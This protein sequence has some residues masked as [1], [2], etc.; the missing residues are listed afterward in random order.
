MNRHSM[1]A[2]LVLSIAAAACGSS[3]PAAVPASTDTAPPEA[4]DAPATTAAS[5]DAATDDAEVS[6]AEIAGRWYPVAVDGVALDTTEGDYWDF[7][8]TDARLEITGFDG[9]NNFG[10][11][12]EPDTASASIVDGRLDNVEIATEEAACEGVDSGPYPEDGADL[13][14]SDDATNLT[15]KGS[16]TTVDLSRTEPVE[17]DAKVEVPEVPEVSSDNGSPTTERPVESDAATGSVDGPLMRHPEPSGTQD[18]M[19]AEVSGV[20]VLDDDCLYLSSGDVGERYP[21]LWPARTAWDAERE[22]VILS[23]GAE[24]AVGAS[25]TGGG[26]YL[27]ASAVETIAD[28]AAGEHAARCVDNTYGEI[29]VVNNYETAIAPT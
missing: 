5:S 6:A 15:A 29:A 22:V 9:C 11:V 24:I 28:S 1:A 27:S 8:G 13:T 7:N 26:G 19:E 16:S 20:L 18:G 21:V 2:V 23:S 4:T 17:A 10:T 25:A 14:V 3:G 12:G